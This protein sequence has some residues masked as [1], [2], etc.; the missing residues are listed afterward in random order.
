M[1]LLINGKKFSTASLKRCK[2]F[3]KTDQ[4]LSFFEV[5]YN[6]KANCKPQIL[7]YQKKLDDKHLNVT[8]Y[9]SEAEDKNS[10]IK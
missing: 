1:A 6:K 4:S 2:I 9:K 7:V 3:I 10:Q 5:Q 8:E